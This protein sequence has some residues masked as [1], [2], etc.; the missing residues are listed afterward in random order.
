MESVKQNLHEML[1]VERHMYR[2]KTMEYLSTSKQYNSF[3][4][5]EAPHEL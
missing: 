4:E 5:E 3:G 2:V 1:H